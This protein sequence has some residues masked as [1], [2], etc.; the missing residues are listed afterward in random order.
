LC[1]SAFTRIM[2]HLLL[3][4]LF[5]FLTTNLLAQGGMQN[6]TLTLQ[7][8]DDAYNHNMHIASDGN[9]YYTCNGGNYAVG[10]INKF[11][12]TGVFVASYQILL[13]MRSIMYNKAD[14]YF[15]ASTFG[16]GLA[17]ITNVE[18]GTFTTLSNFRFDYSQASTAISDDGL[19]VLAFYAGTLKKYKLSDGVLVQTITGLNYGTGNFGGDGAV[20]VDF[21]YIYT[22]N[23]N[24]K[25]VYVYDL[26]GTFVRTMTLSL[27]NNGQSL[28]SV[29][30]ILFVSRDGNYSIGTWYGYKVQNCNLSIQITSDVLNNQL[31]CL[32]ANALLT[33]KIT[34]GGVAPYTYRWSNGST[35]STLRVH[36]SGNYA[37]TITD[38]NGCVS[39]SSIQI[40][41]EPTRVELSFLPDTIPMITCLNQSIRVAIPDAILQQ[42]N[43]FTYVIKRDGTIWAKGIAP[44]YPFNRVFNLDAILGGVYDFEFTPLNTGCTVTDRMVIIDARNRLETNQFRITAPTTTLTCATPTIP[45]SVVDANGNPLV[46]YTYAWTNTDFVGQVSN[47]RNINAAGQYSVWVMNPLTSCRSLLPQTI[48]IQQNIAKPTINLT[49]SNPNF[50]C[51]INQIN[52]TATGGTTYQWNDNTTSNTKTIQNTGTFTVTGT[53]ANGCQNTANITIGQTTGLVQLPRV[54]QMICQGSALTIGNQ[55]FTSAGDYTITKTGILGCDTT[56]TLRLTVEDSTYRQ[57]LSIAAGTNYTIGNSTYSASGAYTNRVPS[58]NGCMR[59]VTT[60]LTVLPAGV[61]LDTN[62]QL[63]N[64]VIPCKSNDF[65]VDITKNNISSDTRGWQ[66]TIFYPSNSVRYMYGLRGTAIPSGYS[67]FWVDSVAG[68]IHVAISAS[69]GTPIASTGTIAQ[70]CFK[71]KPNA[72]NHPP[73]PITASPILETFSDNARNHFVSVGSSRVTTQLNDTMK[74]NMQYCG[75]TLQPFGNIAGTGNA[76]TEI[77]SC[78]NPNSTMLPDAQGNAICKA[79]DNIQIKRVPN[80]NPNLRL[81]VVNSMDAYRIVQFANRNPLAGIPDGMHWRAADVD[82]NGQILANDSYAALRISVGL[83]AVQYLWLPSTQADTFGLALTPTRVS[84]VNNCISMPAASCAAQSMTIIGIQRGD[85]YAQAVANNGQLAPLK[86]EIFMDL[87]RTTRIGDTVVVPIGYESPTLLNAVDLDIMT[88]NNRLRIAK[89]ETKSN[90]DQFLSNLT[91]NLIRS[92]GFGNNI[93]G[94]CFLQ[95]KVIVPAGVTL[96]ESDFSATRSLLNGVETSFGF[97]ATATTCVSGAHDPIIDVVKVSLYPNPTTQ[98]LTIDYNEAVKQLSIVNLLGQSLKTLEINASGRLDVNVSELPNG[99]YFLKINEKEMKKFVK[100]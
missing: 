1:G 55:T 54:T 99:V 56:Y 15:Y 35:D 77:K 80:T 67:D 22:W 10:K 25:I 57:A 59:T 31:T 84:I 41:T 16:G 7:F 30:E 33:P 91:D 20:A 24:S 50:T 5:L 14:R 53:G 92:S 94:L 96:Q 34:T 48:D 52:L 12:L 79:G 38:A 28:S 62:Y 23:S 8:D 85:F 76:Y 86:Q 93:G 26:N 11:T 66:D 39:S 4:S 82:G 32:N 69:V 87:T 45:L 98:Q 51:G 70:V 89:I 6:P 27:G 97:R 72:T 9:Y 65:C 78:A 49:A 17:K 88:N 73:Y 95:M 58:N 75:T 13:D 3:S 21:Q 36:R 19:Y 60:V 40:T 47:T 74:V 63:P 64:V 18:A 83:D 81:S 100:L 90:F 29:N 71:L 43:Q 61:A 2:H 37:V 68:Q 46:G 42:L 44:E